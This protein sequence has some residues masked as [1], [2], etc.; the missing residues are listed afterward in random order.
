MADRGL[1]C[2]SGESHAKRVNREFKEKLF[3][4]VDRLVFFIFSPVN[5]SLMYTSFR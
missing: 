3:V 2:R 1:R 5:L 4:W